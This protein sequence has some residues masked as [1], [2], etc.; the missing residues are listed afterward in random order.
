MEYKLVSFNFANGKKQKRL[1]MF[2]LLRSKT[3]KAGVTALM[4][5]VAP[6]FT[7]EV[8][9]QRTMRGEDMIEARAVSGAADRFLSGGEIYYGQYLL[10]SY[11]KAGISAVQYPVRTDMFLQD[12]C[13]HIVAQGQWMYRLAGTRNRQLNLYGGGGVFLGCE[14]AGGWDGLFSDRPAEEG[15]FSFLYGLRADL[16]A[17]FFI[18]RRTAL[19]VGGS[20]PVNFSSGNGNIRWNAG[21]GF[22]INF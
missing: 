2:N 5:C 3:A 1:I 14:A 17:E 22:R 16:E 4:L 18:T 20:L 11:W 8:K 12:S 19:V 9:A 6:A 10:K 21:A 13:V 7:L 15:R